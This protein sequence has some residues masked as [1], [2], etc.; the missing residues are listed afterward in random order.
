MPE[1][2]WRAAKRPGSLPAAACASRF[3]KCAPLR[4][5]PA[6]KSDQLAE[7]VC[8][9]SLKSNAPG[10]ASWL[11]K[12]EMRRAGSL[13][14][15]LADECAVPGG[16]ALAVDRG[17]FS[18]SV[19]AAID[20]HPLITLRRQEVTE[21]PGDGLT[22]V[23]TGPL[24][25]DRLAES[26]QRLA[27]TE[28]LAFYDSISPIVDADTLNQDRLFRASRYGK[29]GDDYLNSAMTKDEYL[30]FYEAL[31]SAEAVQA[32]EFED[33]KY[34]ES[35]LPIEE[36]ARRGVDTLRFGPMRPVGF[37]DPRTGRRPYA[38]VQL[39]T[40]NLR[41]SSYNLVGFQNHLKF[42]EQKRILRM[43]PGLENAEFLRY[44]QIHRNTYINAPRL[45]SPDLSFRAHPQ[46][47]IAG[48]LS[49]VEGYAECI[50]TGLLA[51]MAL[52]HRVRQ[53]AFA[54]PPRTTALGS[55]VHYVTHA[56]P[57]NYQPANI[58]FDLLPPIEGLP[59]AVARDRRARREKQCERALRDLQ[60]WLESSGDAISVAGLPLDGLAQRA[61][62][63]TNENPD[64][65]VGN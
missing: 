43:I 32:H 39:R 65:L 9:N 24:T 48:Q 35:C 42:P 6:H 28:S 59:P 16:S 64:G 4:P 23:A 27:G 3:A 47:F 50:A 62:P 49:G 33:A 34:F 5:T 53:E 52:A 63:V 44:G 1:A 30:A 10:A 45:L 11:L 56:S 40:E 38:L 19:T 13:L 12:E 15:R 2:V 25:S 61:A 58:A 21:I 14:L 20:Q 46:V 60:P 8:S 22:L 26:L 31:R 54:P 17:R 7:L 57:Q 41:T 55:L 37:V 18:A 29:G 36:L 51:G